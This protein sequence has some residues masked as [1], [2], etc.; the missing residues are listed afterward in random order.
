[1]KKRIVSLFIIGLFVYS[2]TGCGT[3]ETKKSTSAVQ[4]E[5]FVK[6]NEEQENVVFTINADVNHD[7]AEEEMSVSVNDGGAGKKIFFNVTN[8]ETG[9]MIYSKEFYPQEE[10]IAFYLYNDGEKDYLMKY[11]P[12]C[13]QGTA[14]YTYQVFYFDASNEEVVTDTDNVGF[15][16]YYVTRNFDIEAMTNF[17]NKV[18]E[19]LDE[20]ILLVSG[21]DASVLYS[22]DNNFIK[23][24]EEYEFI[25]EYGIDYSDCISISEK[26]G[27]YY[28]YVRELEESSKPEQIQ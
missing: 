4:Q 2:V 25:E 13:E 10:S 11:Q 14:Q 7:G 21:I 15:E 3:L 26:L 20:S 12:Q 28:S 1:M 22:T 17:Y 23:A 24:L 9:Q 18:N 19:Y 6:V 5:N 8:G 27:K 16:T